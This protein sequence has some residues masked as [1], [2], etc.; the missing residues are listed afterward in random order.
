[1]TTPTHRP[2]A[3]QII[4]SDTL[5]S[6]S[7]FAARPSGVAILAVAI[8]GL[9]LTSS[10]PS[11][12]AAGG[13]FPPTVSQQV[14]QVLGGRHVDQAAKWPGGASR[15]LRDIFR[16][17]VSAVPLVIAQDAIG[18]S[19]VVHVD[20][21]TSTALLV[22]NHH[23]VESP[24]VNEK[25]GTRFV[26]L[27]FYESALAAAV[28]DRSRVAHC[29]TTPDASAWCSTLLGVTRAGVIVASDP[30]RDLA[31]VVIQNVPESVRPLPSGTLDAVRSGDDVVV[32][33]HPLGLL[34]SI[35]TGIVSGIRSNY[36][37]SASG[38]ETTVVQTQTPINPGNSGGPLLTTDGQL[39]GVIFAARTVSATRQNLNTDVRVAA[40]G[41]NLAIGVNEVQGFISKRMSAPR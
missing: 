23:V 11:Q 13:P 10:M 38:A 5:P 32:I 33:G 30:S 19:V 24:F 36:P 3:G 7:P 22:T 14:A 35:T 4:R 28:F 27:V 41:L 2:I 15:G 20:R 21:K 1:M 6:R 25:N 26:V 34:W 8:V 12:A 31:L 17:S 9:L 37:M 16:D 40:P 39:I 18:S 29:L